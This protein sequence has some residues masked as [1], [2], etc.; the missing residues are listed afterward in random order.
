MIDDQT[1]YLLAAAKVLKTTARNTC[2]AP[3]NRDRLFLPAYLDFVDEMHK[4]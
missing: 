2:L 4:L 1:G 3:V